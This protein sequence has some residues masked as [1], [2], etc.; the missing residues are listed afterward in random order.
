MSAANAQT[1]CTT[2]PYCGVGC[3]ISA[4]IN[5]SDS[6]KI[7]AVEGDKKHPANGGRLCVKG[8]TVHNTMGDHG[9]L[10]H[11]VVDG[12]QTDWDTAINTVARRLQSVRD[13]YGSGAIAF[14]L[15]GQLLTED[16]YVA[17][18]LAK[19]FI[20]TP[21]VDTNSR[22]CMS[23]AVAAHNR[24]FGADAVP[25][26][27]QDLEQADLLVLTGAN[28]A[29]THP[30]L[31]QRIQ[32]AKARRPTMK[33][34]VIDPRRTATCDIADLHI[35]AAP[36]SD[37]LLFNGLLNFLAKENAT[38]TA[39]IANHTNGF[40]AALEKSKKYSLKFVAKKTGVPIEALRQFYQ[41]FSDTPKTVTFYSQGINQSAK[42]T[43]ACNAIINCHLATGR[44]GK[45]GA[46][47]FSITGQPNA[48]G[49]REVGGLAN[50]LAAHM[51]YSPKHCDLVSEF[52]NA[53]NLPRQPG[54]KAVD[55]YDKV[56]SGDI[57]AIWIMGTNP[58]VS[59][60]NANAVQK[61]LQACDTVIVSDCIAETD[62]T[63]TANILLPAMGWGEKSGTVTNSERCIS[64][65][66][67]LLQPAGDAK[68]DWWI[69]AQVGKAM[70]YHGFE[71]QTPRD[72]FVEH[73]RL[74][75]YKNTSGKNTVH[76][77]FNISG[78][79]DL[80][81]Q[82]YQHL[83]PIRWPI[84]EDAP[85]GSKHLFGDGQFATANGK[86][87]FIAVD[88]AQPHRPLNKQFPLA[89]NSGRIRDQWHTMTRTGRAPKL[90]NHMQAPFVAVHPNTAKQHQLQDQALA[91]ITSAHGTVELQ[92][93][94]DNDIAEGQL[95][96]PIHWNDQFASRA[97]ID[98]LVAPITDTISGQPEFK[99]TPVAIKPVAT[100]CWANVVSRQPLQFDSFD[101]W[102]RTPVTDGLGHSY[103]ASGSAIDWQ[104]WIEQ[105][106][107]EFNG[108]QQLMQMENP[109]SEQ[110]RLSCWVNGQLQ[111][112]LFSHED[113]SALPNTE[114]LHSLMLGSTVATPGA[115]LS[116]HFDS[117]TGKT[118]CACFSVCENK[119]IHSIQNGA[120]SRQEL[121]TQLKCGT[122]CG[123][124]IPELNQL[125]RQHKVTQHTGS[126]SLK[127]N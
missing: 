77:V 95:F 96:V 117:S 8:S 80:S 36:G 74:S 49:G 94:L 106:N 30:V 76:R 43:D 91:R 50:M 55:L 92:V 20:G 126:V 7:I 17:N 32:A 115:L 79:S 97:R 2:C 86:A 34:V 65:Q 82:D 83:P 69:M 84:T 6:K 111:W 60:P 127:V 56:A 123:S 93:Q 15:S 53:P 27:Y 98:S 23:S 87:N 13:Q 62:T 113:A 5:N 4:R 21:H 78:L 54:L 1:V 3:G 28:T 81:E 44:V 52:W 37:T 41:W 58:V 29:W 102:H 42:G 51:D 25:A 124:C 63:A 66:R 112:A 100:S 101:Y 9:R 105:A 33:V 90:L 22:L 46:S 61:A 120:V 59:M 118:V 40:E 26:N 19:G 73:A 125:I 70:G 47:P 14:Y 103:V 35:A 108:E 10:L 57:R 104:G 12:E 109:A 75:A 122:N 85:Y 24:A 71:F 99:Y 116:G 89:L 114:W 72:V 121:G 68:A 107:K 119:I 38:D 39:Y 110:R 31:Y 18:K 48:M 16:Y 88:A 45:P 64:R 11:P 67:G